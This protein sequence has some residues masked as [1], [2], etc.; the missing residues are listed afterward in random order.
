MPLKP[1]DFKNIKH[2]RGIF[3]FLIYYSVVRRIS[4]IS[5]VSVQT[6]S[7]GSPDLEMIFLFLCYHG[8]V[9]YGIL[10][11]LNF[12]FQIYRQQRTTNKKRHLSAYQHFLPVS[13]LTFKS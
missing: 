6:E 11:I 1:H 13:E 7:F 5:N 3:P 12:V 8:L 2:F 4:E 9:R 10:I